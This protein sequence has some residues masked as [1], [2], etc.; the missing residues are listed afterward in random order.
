MKLGKLIS[1][2]FSMLLLFPAISGSWQQ[3]ADF[4]SVGR[5]RG[6]GLSIGNKGYMGLGH[7]N[8]A[9]PNIV[10]K[11]W[12]E[13]D[14]A[15]NSW[16]QKSDY[17]GNN[18]NGNYGVAAFNTEK[19]G[20][21]CGGQLSASDELLRY[22]PVNNQWTQ[23]ASCPIPIAN[24]SAFAIDNKGYVF[25]G[26]Q[27]FEFSEA[28]GQW[29]T[30]NNMP[31]NV[32]TWNSAFALDGKGYAHTGSQFWEYKP[33]N[34]IWISKA[35]FPG[36]ATAG[37]IG[38][39]HADKG[40]IITGYS[41]ALSQVR[42][43]VWEF[44]PGLNQWSQLDDFPGNSRRFAV[45]FTIGNRSYFG[46]GTNGTNFNDFWE[47][48][49]TVGFEEIDQ[50]LRINA[51]PNPAN[52]QFTIQLEDHPNFDVEIYNS[53]HQLVFS[54]TAENGKAIVQR[55]TLPNGIY[56]YSILEDYK[57]IHFDKFIFK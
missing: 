21:I 50:E 26:N 35:T 19:Y 8:G 43:E 23:M 34:D 15:T 53:N 18:G 55:S 4:G 32:G 25:D 6:I 52:E 9:G 2:L 39:G 38:L 37:A 49:G 17:T 7:Y 54:G 20:Y 13:F 33:A 22:D 42:S 45:G 3:R 1:V 57:V 31:F 30:L 16:S 56:Y 12:W 11:D 46:I 51:Y 27:L 47:F 10:F 24:Q 40:Y 48:S 5:H 28:T 14:P 29:T 41:G 36:D 44:D